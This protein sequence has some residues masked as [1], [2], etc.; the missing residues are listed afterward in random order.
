MICTTRGPP[1]PVAEGWAEPLATGQERVERGQH[2]RE[3]IADPEEEGALPIDEAQQRLVDLLAQAAGGHGTQGIHSSV[4]PLPDY[5][6]CPFLT[7]RRSWRVRSG[8]GCGITLVRMTSVRPERAPTVRE[9][10]AS[11]SKSF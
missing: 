5:L 3:I 6:R 4:T 11:G 9:L 8:V 1:P 7:A 2:G 10:L